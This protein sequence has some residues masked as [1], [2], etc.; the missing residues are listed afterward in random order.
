MN[1]DLSTLNNPVGLDGWTLTLNLE[2]GSKSLLL[3]DNGDGYYRIVSN[4]DAKNW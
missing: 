4:I 3:R 2:A 1:Y